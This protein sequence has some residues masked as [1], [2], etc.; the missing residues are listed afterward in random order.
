MLSYC[1][2]MC[3]IHKTSKIVGRNGERERERE[4]EREEGV[5]ERETGRRGR[6]LLEGERGNNQW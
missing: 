4:R 5:I 3:T 6:V 2:M 1:R